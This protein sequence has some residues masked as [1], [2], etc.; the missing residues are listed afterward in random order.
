LKKQKVLKIGKWTSTV[1]NSNEKRIKKLLINILPNYKQIVWTEAKFKRF[2]IDLLNEL[3]SRYK[4]KNSIELSNRLKTEI[5]E[6]AIKEKLND[7]S[8]NSIDSLDHNQL[9]SSISGEIINHETTQN[10]SENIAYTNEESIQATNQSEINETYSAN[11]EPINEEPTNEPEN[12]E[13]NSSNQESTNVEPIQPINESENNLA[14]SA[15][16]EPINEEPTNEPENYESNSSNQESTNVEPIQ[17][18]NESEN[19][20]AYSANPEP[21]NEKPTHTT[22]EPE[23][24]ESNSSNQ[25]STNVEPTQPID[26]S[27][28]NLAY[29]ANPEP[30]NEEPTHTTNKP[31]NHESNSS[32]QESTNVEAIQPIDESESNRAFSANPE[33]INEEPTHTTNESILKISSENQEIKK[34]LTILQSEPSY[35]DKTNEIHLPESDKDTLEVLLE[36]SNQTINELLV[37]AE[38]VF[39]TNNLFD[40]DLP[41]FEDRISEDLRKENIFLDDD[42]EETFLE[43]IDPEEN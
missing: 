31:E 1:Y 12:Y 15:N 29:S 39:T 13:S 23:I 30:I 41:E 42:T 35:F 14:Y 34:E 11:P 7:V 5:I 36:E 22:N 19:N 25:E 20:L 21:I 8:M 40:S 18:I 16:P 2:Y 6:S 27:E 9:T 38:D 37:E 26:E 24:Y 17:P 28:N 3:P 32:N 10:K 4:Q 43:I 33:P